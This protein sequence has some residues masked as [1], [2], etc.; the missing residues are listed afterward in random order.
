MN[1]LKTKKFVNFIDNYA[2]TIDN[3]KIDYGLLSVIINNNYLEEKL[4]EPEFTHK[5]DYMM[6][7]YTDYNNTWSMPA[8]GNPYDEWIKTHEIAVS[9]PE[10]KK[11]ETID[12]SMQT[13]TDIIHVLETH[14]YCANTEYN[15]D[16]KSLHDIKKELIE[17]N[18]MIGLEKLKQSI[19]EQLMYFSQGL[20]LGINNS[21]FKHAVISGSPGTGKTEIAKIIGRMYSKM[22]I[23]KKNTFKK[24]T[25]HDLVA[26]YLGQTAIKTR[27][28]I[29]ESLGGVLFIDEAYSLGSDDIY[30]KECLD[31]LCEA[32]SDHKDDLMVIIAGYENELNETFFKVNTGLNSR[33]IWRFSMGEYSAKELMQIFKKKVTEQGWQMNSETDIAESWFSQ[34]KKHFK[35]FGRDMEMLLLYTKITHGKRIYGK[36][37]EYR[38]K[39]TAADLNGGFDMF[40]KNKK[41]TEMPEY[42][43]GIYC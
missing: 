36:P 38:K 42:L 33:F 11:Q 13:L 9:P 5:Q 37:A 8:A 20:H 17:L 32:L 15:I 22:G 28:V 10:P 14:P 21:E 2:G 23:L 35:N 16:L 24:V 31:T 30:S 25:R 7:Y 3:G 26:G 19:L 34:K 1:K 39:I 12:A 43:S 41:E 27:K 6:Y 18:Q 4:Y 29:D 40:T